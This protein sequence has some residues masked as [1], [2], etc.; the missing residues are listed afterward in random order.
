[1]G[2]STVCLKSTIPGVA[3]GISTFYAF[4]NLVEGEEFIDF[5]ITL[6]ADFLRRWFRPQVNFSFDGF[7]PFKP[8][9]QDQAFAMFEWGFN[10]VVAQHS[11]QYL[12]IH[13]AVLEKNGKALI[14]PGTPGSG[15]STLCAALT[16]RGWRLL[17]DEMALVEVETGLLQPIPRP[18]SLKNQ[19]IDIIKQFAPE[20]LIGEPVEDTAKGTVAHVRA[21]ESSVRK[22]DEKVYP[23]AV[24]FPKYKKGSDTE[25]TAISAGVGFMKVAEN[26]FNYSL[27][28]ET[29]FDVLGSMIDRCDCYEFY[30]QDLDEAIAL[31]DSMVV[32]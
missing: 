6:D 25:L 19:S 2:F 18:I 26:S 13:S 28:G 21:P 20:F 17:S 4:N 8:L 31:F 32:A 12:V 11:Q 15:K 14:F 29:G 24:I 10:W 16:S 27:L 23:T 1:M 9:P 22:T 7:H 5:H 30:Y 3:E